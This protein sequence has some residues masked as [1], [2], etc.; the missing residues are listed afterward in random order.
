LLPRRLRARRRKT[1]QKQKRRPAGT[2]SD[3]IDHKEASRF[4]QFARDEAKKLRRA[5]ASA[6]PSRSRANMLIG[7]AQ[8]GGAPGG[9]ALGARMSWGKAGRRD[10]CDSCARFNE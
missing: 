6:D 2:A 7:L 4:G 10:L 3:D 5:G 9:A 8:S 1:A